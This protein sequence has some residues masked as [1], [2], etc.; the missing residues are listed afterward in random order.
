MHI[1]SWHTQ[2]RIAPSLLSTCGS[3]NG[4]QLSTVYITQMSVLSTLKKKKAFIWGYDCTK[5]T[6][7]TDRVPVIVINELTQIRACG[8]NMRGKL[9][10]RDFS[11]F[12]AASADTGA[13]ETRPG[14]FMQHLIITH[15]PCAGRGVSRE[16]GSF[17]A[18]L[19]A[20][21][22]S[23]WVFL[24]TPV[25]HWAQRTEVTSQPSSALSSLKSG[26]AP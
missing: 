12:K 23:D 15:E 8:K 26:W 3:E 16:R 24:L 11:R 20:C 10:T 22:R 17:A 14:G 25:T 5:G 6:M 4:L 9:I 19:S 21:Q 18:I 13:A 7:R 2:K 1:I